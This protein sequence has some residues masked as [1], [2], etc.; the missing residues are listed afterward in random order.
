[1]TATVSRA[2]QLFQR[3][4][5]RG[6]MPGGV[7]MVRR[8]GEVVMA[9]AVGIARGLRDDEGPP[10]P[11]RV[12]T[13]F[14]VMSVSKAVVAFAIAVLEDRGLIDVGAPVA[15]YFPAFAQEGKADVTVLDVL[16]H[17]SGLTLDDLVRTPERWSDWPGLMEAVA[18][19]RPEHRRGALAY[20]AYSFGWILGEL[21]RRVTGRTLPEFLA[22]VLP[23]DMATG[24]RLVASEDDHR[25]AR[26]YW[27][28]PP[29]YKL[30]RVSL[31]SDFERIN[32][33]IAC[34]RALVP[35]AGMVATADALS[36]FYEALLRGGVTA[37]GQR[38]LKAEVLRRYVTPQTSGRDRITGAWVTLG[39][40]FALGWALPHPYGWWGSGACFGHPGGFGAM[41]FADPGAGTTVVILTNA[42]RGVTDLVRRFAPLSHVARRL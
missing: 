40:G 24:L 8:R 13:P 29:G 37:S 23:A 3:Q 6:L 9:E 12:D 25:P 11:M 34:F 7:M 15:R 20:E 22:E 4:H 39:R 26:N 42:H 38:L 17:R 18:A 1:V 33:G 16:T 32:N 31:A 30:G 10:E 36:A 5:A 21:V 19:A 14:Q 2:R 41:A 27:L 28:G 35:G